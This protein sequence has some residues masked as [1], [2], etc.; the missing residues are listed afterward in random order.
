MRVAQPQHR[1]QRHLPSARSGQRQLGAERRA[2]RRIVEVARQAQSVLMSARSS[3]R[4][5][6]TRGASMPAPR[7][8][9]AHRLGWKSRSAGVPTTHTRRAPEP[10]RRRT[11]RARAQR[12]S[13]RRRRSAAA[14]CARGCRR[15]RSRAAARCGTPLA[16]TS[17]GVGDHVDADQRVGMVG[18]LGGELLASA[19]PRSVDAAPARSRARRSCPAPGVS[20]R[21]PWRRRRPAPRPGPGACRGD[22]AG[23][24]GTDHD[25]V[26]ALS[27]IQL[28]FASAGRCSTSSTPW[29]I[30]SSKRDLSQLVAVED[31]PNA[32]PALLQE[33][34]QRGVGLP[35]R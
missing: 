11:S 34:Q 10:R 9:S 33:L 1:R 25:H 31:R 23:G 29:K 2:P 26:V 14:G 35:R 27:P 3:F 17:Q 7:R 19:G 21:R 8:L 30:Q 20:S 15:R 13:A 24:A 6:L 5:T 22:Q 18:A 28:A 12:A 32:L 4:S 16:R